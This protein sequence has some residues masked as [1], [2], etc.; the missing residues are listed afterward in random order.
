MEREG[1]SM[2]K[3]RLVGVFIILGWLA[4]ACGN[5]IGDFFTTQTAQSSSATAMKW[6][7]TPS[8]TPTLTSTST[9]TRTPSPSPSATPDPRFVEKKGAILFSYIPPKGWSQKN[10]DDLTGWWSQDTNNILGFILVEYQLPL[11]DFIGAYSMEIYKTRLQVGAGSSGF[12]YSPENLQVYK[13]VHW[14]KENNVV[15]RMATF[16]VKQEKFILVAVFAR[17]ADSEP[18]FDD[19]VDQC[20]R[21]LRFE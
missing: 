15:F 9:R 21:T 7:A 20:I 6:T 1:F 11:M 8:V 14:F 17:P 2:G 18:K 19:A 16:F 13:S 3:I 10:S 12:F 4:L 5:P